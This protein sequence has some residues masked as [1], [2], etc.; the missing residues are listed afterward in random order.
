[1][2]LPVSAE[3]LNHHQGVVFCRHKERAA[4][5]RMVKYT[6]TAVVITDFLQLTCKEQTPRTTAW[7]FYPRNWKWLWNRRLGTDLYFFWLLIFYTYVNYTHQ[8]TDCTTRALHKHQEL[9]LPCMYNS[10]FYDALH[11]ARICTEWLPDDGWIL[12][13]KHVAAT[14]TTVQ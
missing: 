11:A 12:Q 8:H 7:D 14:V 9:L 6:H 4:C 3:E 13:P 2:F 1:M 5:H 10:L